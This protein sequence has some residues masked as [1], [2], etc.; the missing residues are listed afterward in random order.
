MT[1]TKNCQLCCAL[2]FC[3]ESDTD[4]R[5][6]GTLLHRI[7][8][9]P[10]TKTFRDRFAPQWLIDECSRKL[11]PDGTLSPADLDLYTRAIMASPE[12]LVDPAP[13]EATFE[14][15][16]YPEGGVAEG[17]V[18]VDGS[19]LDAEHFLGGFCARQGWAFAAYD[20]QDELQAAAHGRTPAWASGTHATELW[21]LLMAA[22]SSGA[23]C[24][25][26]VDCLAVQKGSQRGLNWAGAPSR[27][28]ARAWGPLAATLEEDSRR[29]IWMPAHCGSNIESKTLS[30]GEALKHSD[31]KGNAYVDSLAKQ[32]AKR[33]RAPRQQVAK[34]SSASA[35][36][37]GIAMWIGQ[38]T[39]CANHFPD[40][41][42]S[43]QDGK[44]KPR[45][46]RDS[47]GI[48]NLQR[49]QGRRRVQQQLT[50]KPEAQAARAGAQQLLAYMPSSGCG[51]KRK[52]CCDSRAPEKKRLRSAVGS[53]AARQQYADAARVTAWLADRQLAAQAGPSATERLEAL[54]QR[55][56]KRQEASSTSD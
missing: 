50:P 39:A 1:N 42:A 20:D 52:A 28:F 45:F 5:F 6:T 2:G 55:V 22:Q 54:R 15:V 10:A 23:F 12:P 9:C 38:I 33:D 17:T 27:K 26:K 41:R 51:Y 24:P 30:N 29:V 36:L 37:E 34:V 44:K 19:R 48:G 13:S 14:W 35:R 16:K 4:P 18:Y 47:T 56:L 49:T 53:W 3:D 8:T 21:G 43:A 31:V 7:F 32:I 46:L 11:R 40:P 25:L